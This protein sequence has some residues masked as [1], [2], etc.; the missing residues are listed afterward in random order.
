MCCLLERAEFA[1][2]K[3]EV[4]GVQVIALGSHEAVWSTCAPPP[5]TKFECSGPA[6]RNF[7]E[8]PEPMIKLGRYRSACTLF[9]LSLQVPR[10]IMFYHTGP[11]S[12]HLRRMCGRHNDALYSSSSGRK[13]DA[14]LSQGQYMISVQRQSVCIRFA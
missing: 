10:V 13:G 5:R 1:A 3:W 8:L 4:A 11:D 9:S 6:A 7:K 12:L 2:K 14:T